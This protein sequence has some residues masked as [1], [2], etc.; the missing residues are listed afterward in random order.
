MFVFRSQIANREMSGIEAFSSYTNLRIESQAIYS[1]EIIDRVVSVR[2][3]WL[4]RLFRIITVQI[5]RC[6]CCKSF[7]IAPCT[8]PSDRES[9]DVQEEIVACPPRSLKPLSPQVQLTPKHR[10]KVSKR[11]ERWLGNTDPTDRTSQSSSSIT[12][13]E[14]QFTALIISYQL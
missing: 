5:L 3:N 7:D 13:M 12:A 10:P 14:Y 6:D 11:E 1:Q 2:S 4:Y 8:T 9:N